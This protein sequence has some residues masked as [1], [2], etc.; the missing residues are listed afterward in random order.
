MDS[1]FKWLESRYFPRSY[2]LKDKQYF[3]EIEKMK[4]YFT[5][6][7]LKYISILIGMDTVHW[8]RPRYTSVGYLRSWFLFDYEI[9]QDYLYFWCR[10]AK[11]NSDRKVMNM[12]LNGWVGNYQKTIHSLQ[13]PIELV[14]KIVSYLDTEIPIPF[15]E[16][17]LIRQ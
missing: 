3:V 1:S 4:Q 16:P 7:E 14:D 11:T 17:I 8:W 2:M 15:W 13:L 5:L 9:V 10:L 6:D 12:F